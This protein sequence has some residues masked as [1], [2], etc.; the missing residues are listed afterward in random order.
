MRGIFPDCWASAR[1]G[2]TS[3]QVARTPITSR[4]LMSPPARAA[5]GAW[6]P[7]KAPLTEHAVFGDAEMTFRISAVAACCSAASASARLRSSFWIWAWRSEPPLLARSPLRRVPH[8]GQNSSWGGFSWAHR[9]HFIAKPPRTRPGLR[10]RDDSPRLAAASMADPCVGGA[11]VR[12]DSDH[13]T[14][15]GHRDQIRRPIHY[16][17]PRTSVSAFSSQYVIPI[18]RYIVVAVVRTAREPTLQP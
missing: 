13:Q 5:Y 3:R 9:E 14:L 12:R 16:A 10:H 17:K 6:T 7:Q 15:L 8:S 2:V 18:S 4:R 1:R 11:S